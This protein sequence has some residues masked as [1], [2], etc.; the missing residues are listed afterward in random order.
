MLR[1]QQSIADD[2]S[3]CLAPSARAHTRTRAADGAGRGWGGGKCSSMRRR[4]GVGATGR[5]PV[6]RGDSARGGGAGAAGDREPTAAAAGPACLATVRRR[7]RGCWAACRC[8][9]LARLC[10]RTAWSSAP[11][12]K[13]ES[14]TGVWPDGPTRVDAALGSARLSCGDGQGRD[15]ARWLL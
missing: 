8:G 9:A 2:L 12:A 3:A 7:G 10:P 6:G 13:A 1:W 11:P 4:R 15:R 5:R 14:R